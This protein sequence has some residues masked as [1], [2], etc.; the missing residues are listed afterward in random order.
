M[1]SVGIRSIAVRLPST[2]RTNDYYR[3]KFPTIVREL[4]DKSARASVFDDPNATKSH[5]AWEIEMASYSTDPFRGSVERRRLGPGE[6]PL[7]LEQGAA[8]EALAAAG[9]RPEDVDLLICSSFI[10]ENVN[11]GDATYLAQRLGLRSSAFNIESACSGT[12]V[13]L[14]TACSMVRAGEYHNVLVVVCSTYSTRATAETVAPF[15]LLGDGAGAFVVGQVER[16]R[17]LL[18]VKS[19]HTGESCGLISFV[20]GDNHNGEPLIR[21]RAEPGAGKVM[22]DTAARVLPVCCHG[23]AEAAGVTLSDIDFFVFNTPVAWF[24]RFASR[25]LEIDP[26]KTL[27]TFPIYGNMSLAL[28]TTNLYHA[29]KA[30]LIREG[31]LVLLFSIG[32][33]SSAA[34]AVMRWSRVGLGP[35]PAPS[36]QF[37]PF[38]QQPTL[39]IG[40]SA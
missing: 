36:P 28:T 2:I 6:T 11:L 5:D 33:A 31:S 35:E 40:A 22:R 4:E 25:V 17:G 19:V 8:E 32:S 30:G 15:W 13:S 29:A 16:G 21:A 24:D 1:M 3:K 12:I 26:A 27:T 39:E 10:P 14:Q 9:L 37:G 34:A 23:A 38:M 20:A 7:S 18:G